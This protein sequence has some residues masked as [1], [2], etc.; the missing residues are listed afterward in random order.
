MHK[1]GII[2][3]FF[4]GLLVLLA[5][6]TFVVTAIAG[7]TH[8]T[9]LVSDRFVATVTSATTDP[10][11]INSLGTRIADQVVD[12][13][14]LQQRLSAQLPGPLSRLAE[15]LTQAVHDQ[16]ELAADKVLSS[17]QFQSFFATALT[18]LH[19]GLLNVVNGNS[20]YF[21]TTNG[22]LTLD[23]LAVMDAVIAQL[24]T[25]GVLPTAADF[26]RFAQAA[27]RTDFINKLSA[28]TQAQLPPDFGQIP[29]ADQSSIDTIANALHLFDVSLVA[30][31]VLAMVL[32]LVAVVLADRRWNAI[33]WLGFASVFFFGLLILALGGVQGYADSAVANPDNRVLLAALVRSLAE[34][35]AEWLW[36]IGVVT[37]IV[38]VIAGLLAHRSRKHAEAQ[39][40]AAAATAGSATA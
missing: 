33:A 25:D 10:A 15:P 18:G 17:P 16:I 40:I 37:L 32:A 29:I 30:A 34:S 23:L 21:T 38:A 28:Y 1:R 35:L 6:L 8:Q 26:P 13:L 24:Q 2:H 19:N 7:W 20:A 31:A 5:S 11:V 9:A 12:K 22:K 36:V 3:N 4:V 14:G 39:L 27:D